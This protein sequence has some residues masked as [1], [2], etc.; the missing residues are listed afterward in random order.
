VQEVEDFPED[1]REALGGFDEAKWSE[2]QR[3]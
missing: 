1:V 3:K 2:G